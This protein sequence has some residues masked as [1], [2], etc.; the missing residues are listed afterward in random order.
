[1]GIEHP[2]TYL[3]ILLPRL[4]LL[5]FSFFGDATIYFIGK[6][7]RLNA[8]ACVLT[9]ST[10]YVTMV[11]YTRTF[12]NTFEALLYLAFGSIFAREFSP[13]LTKSLSKRNFSKRE[14]N[15]DKKHRKSKIFS[16]GFLLGII[17][18]L[19][20]YN[21]ATFLI[22][23][24]MPFVI[25]FT[26]DDFRNMT[27]LWEK[28]S[29]KLYS[30]IISAMTT[31]FFIS[32]FDTYY[33]RGLTPYDLIKKLTKDG[34]YHVLFKEMIHVPF[35]FI[36]YY[37]QLSNLAEHG[38]RS[39]LTHFFWNTSILYN[40]LAFYPL[41]HA[42]RIYQKR[43]NSSK[44]YEMPTVGEKLL[45][46]YFIPILLLSIFPQQ[47]PRFLI[48]LLPL[49]CFLYSEKLF[50]CKNSFAKYLWIIFNLSATVFF[51][52][53]HQGGVIRALEYT[54]LN[55]STGN[56]FFW[57]TYMPPK[58]LLFQNSN[59]QRLQI[60]DLM[61]LTSQMA[62][63]Q[64]NKSIDTTP[65]YLVTSSSQQLDFCS[66]D[67]ICQTQEKL[68][69]HI[70]MEDLPNLFSTC[71][72]LNQPMKTSYNCLINELS[73]TIYRISKKDFQYI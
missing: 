4:T 48:P 68:F 38:I 9:Y 53:I 39:R 3:L 72:L 25:W 43:T 49:L 66:E 13:V 1:M 37:A 27:E 64:I 34:L 19:G 24:L 32:L 20:F 7:F 65:I 36:S 15:F 5:I 28:T 33:F 55:N 70:T 22:F 69:P 62:Y 50:G 51:S 14:K 52:Q 44:N 29:H 10:S 6:K 60:L 67:I 57:K 59:K 35:N 63:K 30:L 61:D 12:T 26:L 58:H 31:S 23:T 17:T 71:N 18:A 46:I 21:R 42:Y 54:Q 45:L 47:E 40:V 73:L 16:T 41:L 8:L 2:S 56:L 11:F